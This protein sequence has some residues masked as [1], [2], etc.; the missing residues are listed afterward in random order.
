[1]RWCGAGRRMIKKSFNVCFGVVV[2]VLQEVILLGKLAQ[3]GG[4]SGSIKS[5]PGTWRRS[6]KRTKS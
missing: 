5:P 4:G 6:N 1:M 3:F 2:D